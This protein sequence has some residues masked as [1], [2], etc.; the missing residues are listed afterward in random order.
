MMAWKLM[1][2]GALGVAAKNALAPPLPIPALIA[3]TMDNLDMEPAPIEPD[4]IVDGDPQAR[5]AMHSRAHDDQAI[6]AVWDCTA[7][8]FRWYFG[9]DETVF[10]LE[11]E[12]HVT[13]EDGSER[14]LKAG[15]LGYFAGKTWATWRVDSYV[16]KI[17]FCRKPFPAPVSLAYRLRD[18]L[19]GAPRGGLAA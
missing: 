3:A 1:L 18:R 8:T 12:V 13:A 16:R 19:R 15:D 14:T 4:W 7:G 11:G 10:I 17:A 6:T 2:A 9:W 5:S